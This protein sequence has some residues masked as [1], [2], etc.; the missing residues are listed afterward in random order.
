MNWRDIPAQIARSRRQAQ[1]PVMIWFMAFN[2][3]TGLPAFG[4]RADW[5]EADI[6]GLPVA[7]KN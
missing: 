1:P 2:V 3:T 4:I 6:R 5:Y 7:N